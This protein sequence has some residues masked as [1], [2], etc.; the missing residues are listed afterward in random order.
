MY[1]YDQ[2]DQAMVDARVEEFRDQARRR[3]EGKLTE[4]QFKPL[5]LMNGLYLQ[6]HAYM[7]RV[8]IPYGTLDSRQMHALADIAD[9]YDRGYGHFT[10]RQNIQYNWIRL[11][12]AADILADLA[13]VEMHAIQTSGNCI[14]N[15]SSDHFAGAAA[16]EVVDPRPYAELLRQW[17]SF[18]PEFS[19]LPR[20]FKIAVI[21]SEKDRAAMRLHDIGIN[22][23]KNDAGELGAAFYVGGGMGRTPMIAPCINPFVPLDQLVTY[24]E[25]CLRVYNRYGRRDNK[26][27]ARI[28]ILVHELGAEEYTRQVEEEFAH[29][30]EQGVE[31]PHDE[32]MRIIRMFEA[33]NTDQTAPNDIDRSDPD[34]ALWVDRN[35]VAHKASGYV[36]AVISLKPVGGI[37]GDATAKQMHLMADLAKEYS[38][39]ELRVMHT[40]NIVLPHV[41]KADLHALW[42]ALDQAG[43][44]SPNLDTVEDIIA[45]PGLDYCSLANARSIPIA[46]RISER[47]AAKGKTGTLGELKLKISGCI[48]ACGHHHAGHIG[49]LGVDRKGVENYQLLLG[50]SEAEDVSL[51]KITGPGFDENGIVNAVETVTTVYERERQ[52]G[53]RFVDTYRRIGMNPFKEALYG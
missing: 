10:T 46:Q 47:F 19:Y 38:F 35:T 17:S 45:C 49:I 26:Y 27:K 50:G 2:Y 21:A 52:D 4:D 20:K 18:H 7:L 29:L 48:N 9:K 23:V 24:C 14:R 42:T 12:D 44:G 3:L 41:R 31:P 37:P 11:E 5:R 28:K 6:L 25:A 1:K 30:L 36:S 51:A 40:Q 8:A 13:K 39:D 32:L 16:D 34:F 53:E 33:P 43:L 15:I 22:I